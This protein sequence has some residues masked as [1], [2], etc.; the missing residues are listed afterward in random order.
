M[1]PRIADRLNVVDRHAHSSGISSFAERM[2]TK[3]ATSE[4]A[5]ITSESVAA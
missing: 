2:K 4:I 3:E 5:V 1:T